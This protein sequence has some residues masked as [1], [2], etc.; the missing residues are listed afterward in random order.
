MEELADFP[1]NN[2]SAISV[3]HIPGL[4]HHLKRILLG[5]SQAP[6]GFVEASN[7]PI[8]SDHR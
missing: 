7:A 6:I 1:I 5:K 8:D 4:R 2:W 3:P